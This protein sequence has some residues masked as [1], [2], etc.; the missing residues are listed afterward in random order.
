VNPGR[1]AVPAL[2]CAIAGAL[3]LPGTPTA[4]LAV[5]LAGAAQHPRTPGAAPLWRTHGGEVPQAPSRPPLTPVAPDAGSGEE[6]AG[7][8]QGETD[9]LV[10]NG[11][12]SPSC[13]GALGGELSPQDRDNCET[14]GFVAAPAPTGDYGID[15]HIDTDVIGFSVDSTVQ[16]LLITPLWLMLVWVVHALIVMLE[17]SFTVDL[18]DSAAAGGLARGLRQA[19]AAFTTPW[20]PLVL[21]VASMLALYHGLVRRRVAETVGEALLMGAMMVGGVWVIADPTGTVG[22]LGEWANEAA[23]GTLA[24][25]A[26]GA[27]STPGQALGTSLDAMFAAAVEAPWCYLEFG[28]VSWCREPARLD[29][30]LRAAG[31]AIAA[32]EESQARCGSECGGGGSPQTLRHSAQLLRDARNNGAVFLA[33]PANGPDRN[34]I[35]E[36]GSL[37]R[38]IC[39]SSDATA[40]RGPT[41][42]QAE[43]R[44]AGRTMARLA[45]LLLIAAGLLGM[46]LLLGLV[47]VRLLSA[48]I[49]ALLYLLLA[50]AM[51]LAPAFGEGGRALFRR[52]VAQLLGAIVSKLLFSFLL[53][54][55]FA[56]L[57]VLSNLSAIGWWTQWLLTSAFW[58]SAYKRRHQPLGALGG[59][60]G[61]EQARHR[62]VIRRL[63][64]ALETRTVNNAIGRWRDKRGRSS[65]PIERPRTPDRM[66]G[67]RSGASPPPPSPAVS[68]RRQAQGTLGLEHD[69]ASEHVELSGASEQEVRALGVRLGRIRLERAKALAG[70]DRRR[71]LALELR[72]QRVEGE[73][74]R[75]HEALTSAQRVAGTSREVYAREHLDAR[76]RFLDAQAALPGS[77]ARPGRGPDQGTRAEPRRDYPRL[78]GLAGYGREEYEGLDPRSQRTARLRID[79]ELA[80]RGQMSNGVAEVGRTAS[81]LARKPSIG[82][83]RHGER[84]RAMSAARDRIDP[85]LLR[86]ARES[87]VMR[88]AREVA[89]GRKR[90]LG[91][92][93]P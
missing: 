56:V 30:A 90:Q 48:A 71:A 4:A 50:P 25:A 77:G 70:G 46:S 24:V 41:A 21:A 6:A 89:A 22:A 73:A 93:R 42:P 86:Q 7:S 18:L 66:P 45:G 64:D 54:V 11:L 62:S 29:P 63:G 1:L 16:D 53:G 38:T 80:L 92:D 27:P 49:L 84:E 8:S 72:G 82:A 61:R 19:Q 36:Q 43:F 5:G 32:R 23:L 35:N 57:T 28:D 26:H 91:R 67:R 14:S 78:A 52:W 31:V 75:K 69:A 37:L 40:C 12:G 9:P 60:A 59:A 87:S 3:S 79:R 15:V 65:P 74:K 2:V 58:W 51:V 13:K 55:M 44:T 85:S 33:L 34:S 20:L 68:M 81:D 39:A 10:S 17:W 88:D 76:E 83:S 47:A